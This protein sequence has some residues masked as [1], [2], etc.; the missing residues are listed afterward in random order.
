MSTFV[1]LYDGAQVEI[2]H[3][4]AGKI[5]ENRLWF[6]FDVPPITQTDLDGLAAG[7]AA[8]WNANILPALSSDLTTIAIIA[9]EWSSDP[10]PLQSIINQ[11][12]AG[13]SS[14]PSYSANVAVVVPFKWTLG[15]REKK[16]KNYVSGIPDDAVIFNE[17]Q[18]VFND[19]LFEGYAS[20]VDDARLFYP[21][22]HWRWV[23]T[24]AFDNNAPRSEQFWRSCQGVPQNTIFKLGQRRRRLP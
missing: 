18:P 14:S 4:L 16:N 17:V 12:V 9:R 22:L 19:L 23:V 6:K 20:L 21:V 5:I 1:P 7:A 3:L 2:L 13:G 8:W 10:P 11:S 15:T 24:S